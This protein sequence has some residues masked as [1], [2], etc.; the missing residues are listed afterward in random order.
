M[1]SAWMY[2]GSYRVP[3][4]TIL[5]DVGKK[6]IAMIEE[7]IGVG[8]IALSDHRSSC[9]TTDEL[10]RLVEHAR[11]GGMLGGKAR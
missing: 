4:P 3:T 5:G 7:V 2:T 11:V 10:I 6:D 9:P 8:E 1:F